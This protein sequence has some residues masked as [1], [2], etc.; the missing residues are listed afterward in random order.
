MRALLKAFRRSR[1]AEQ[2]ESFVPRAGWVMML[3]SPGRRSSP[4]TDT[5]LGDGREM[6]NGLT[7]IGSGGTVIVNPDWLGNDNSI[8][9]I[10][11]L[12]MPLTAMVTPKVFFFKSVFQN[13]GETLKLC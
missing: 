1:P 2:V 6:V 7:L 3:C 5:E 4:V 11:R 13:D 12:A 9:N 8:G 10:R